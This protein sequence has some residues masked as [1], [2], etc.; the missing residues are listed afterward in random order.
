MITTDMG[1]IV[2]PDSASALRSRIRAAMEDEYLQLGC[3]DRPSLSVL[4]SGTTE[5][6]VDPDAVALEVALVDGRIAALHDH[7]AAAVCDPSGASSGQVVLL[8][9]GEGPQLMLVSEV[10]FVDD[11]VIA[12]DSPLGEALRHAEPGQVVVYDTPGGMRQVRVI[13]VEVG[14]SRTGSA[15][16]PTASGTARA[17]VVVPPRSSPV[18]RGR[19]VVGLRGIRE[20]RDALA[21]GFAEA[22]RRGTEL[23]VTVIRDDADREGDGLEPAFHAPDTRDLEAAEDLA[24]A[25]ADVGR[26]FP[27]V[28]VSSHLRTGHFADVLVDLSR[29]ADLVVLGMG[30]RPVGLGRSDLLVA[31]HADCPVI[32]VRENSTEGT[33]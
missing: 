15:A 27:S 14:A 23:S 5:D 2:A 26:G 33:S 18:R 11:Q 25:V 22:N 1:V 19:V 21:I 16:S 9:L 32:V 17:T 29:S 30:R 13:A 28:P 7:L 24:T 12:A 10:E 31:T 20:A 8:D 3:L 6:G 4:T